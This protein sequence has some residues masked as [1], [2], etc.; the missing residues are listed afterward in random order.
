MASSKERMNRRARRLTHERARHATHF[1]R[2]LGLD[3]VAFIDL[4]R[5]WDVRPVVPADAP[6]APPFRCPLGELVGQSLAR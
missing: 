6:P 1:W 3:G 2:L 4:G 5:T